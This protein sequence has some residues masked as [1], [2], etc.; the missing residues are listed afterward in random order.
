MFPLCSWWK[1]F[2][3]LFLWQCCIGNVIILMKKHS[4]PAS[5]PSGYRTL[6]VIC[7]TVTSECCKCLRS[8][9]ALRGSRDPEIIYGHILEEQ[10]TSYQDRYKLNRGPD[11]ASPWIWRKL[12]L[13]LTANRTD[14]VVYVIKQLW[15]A[16]ENFNTSIICP[17]FQTGHK[18][19][20]GR[21][22]KLHVN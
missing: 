21:N 15:T 22:L 20:L 12:P 11:P 18:H 13:I 5:S 8:L 9:P 10:E 3:H 2:F 7:H 1:Q 14:L 4:I 19:T 6:Q 16:W 17:I